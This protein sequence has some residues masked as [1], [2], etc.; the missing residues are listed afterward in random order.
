MSLTVG[1]H[2]RVFVG[3]LCTLG[4]KCVFQVIFAL[5]S[6]SLCYQV[7]RMFLMLNYWGLS[8]TQVVYTW[9]SDPGEYNLWVRIG[10]WL[11]F[12]GRHLFLITQSPLQV[13]WISPG[14]AL[15]GIGS[16]QGPYRGPFL[17]PWMG[18]RTKTW[19]LYLHGLPKY[20]I[21]LETPFFFF[22]L[23]FSPLLEPEHFLL[24]SFFKSVLQ[25]VSI[26]TLWQCSNR[27]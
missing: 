4:C 1:W 18:S 21:P 19:Q 26:S 27:S 7:L 8:V 25:W 3:F 20:Q 6:G 5:A 14:C 10:F 16:L 23:A 17:C 11:Q 9:T 12:L 15:K 24:F 22:F 13:G 2:S